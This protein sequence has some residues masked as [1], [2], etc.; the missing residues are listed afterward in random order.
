MKIR[1]ENSPEDLV[2]FNRHVWQRSST[3]RRLL[4]WSRL[5]IALVTTLGSVYLAMKGRHWAWGTP[6]AIAGVICVWWYPKVFA[7]C[8]DSAARRLFL[9]RSHAGVLGPHELL[10]ADHGLVE[11]SEI[12]SQT[13]V[14]QA[15]ELVETS[16]HVFIHISSAQ[17]HVIPRRDVDPAVLR[18]V[19]D[20]LRRRT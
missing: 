13:T 18:G 19:L 1:Y 2:A 7:W 11:V 12:G 20:E 6:L 8:V 16:E 9:E 15:L 3:L 17:A 10:L 4:T 5:S 14:Y